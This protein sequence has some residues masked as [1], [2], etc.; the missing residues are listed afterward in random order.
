MH[1]DKMGQTIKRRREIL[2]ITQRDLADL[3]NI[4]LRTLKALENG[5]SNPTLETLNKLMDVLGM[6][7]SIDVKKNKL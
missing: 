5:R 4:G 2:A 7:L 6:E 3:S 1:P